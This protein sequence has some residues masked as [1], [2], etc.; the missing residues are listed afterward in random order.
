[1]VKHKRMGISLAKFGNAGRKSKEDCQNWFLPDG[2]YIEKIEL[3]Y[4]KAGIRYLHL[5][6]NTGVSISRGHKQ[7]RDSQASFNFDD[8]NPFIGFDGY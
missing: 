2:E 7:I 5:T 8:K 3:S 4:G 6:T 1:M